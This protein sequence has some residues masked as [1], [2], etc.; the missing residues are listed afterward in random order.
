M[1]VWLPGITQ[2]CKAAGTLCESTSSLSTAAEY[3]GFVFRD[4][5]L[6][7]SLSVDP[8]RL[9][10]QSEGVFPGFGLSRKARNA[11]RGD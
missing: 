6:Q 3:P 4:P 5:G 10:Q 8:K 11:R 1:V 7:P 9:G 2:C